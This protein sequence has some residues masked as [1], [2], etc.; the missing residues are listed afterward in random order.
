MVE[1]L[2]VIEASEDTMAAFSDT[3]MAHQGSDLLI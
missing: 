2:L 1:M 3:P